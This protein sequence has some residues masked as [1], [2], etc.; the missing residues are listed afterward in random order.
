[1]PEN[2]LIYYWKQLQ[3]T[4]QKSSDKEHMKRGFTRIQWLAQQHVFNLNYWI[5]CHN[6]NK[7]TMHSQHF[8]ICIYHPLISDT[9]PFVNS[10]KSNKKFYS[11]D[12][13]GVTRFEEKQTSI[14]Y[15]CHMNQKI[16]SY[17]SNKFLDMIYHL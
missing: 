7:N 10:R 16:D 4:L 14:F 13:L 2:A 6:I 15:F 11:T 9:T 17:Q 5:L 8:C 1:M 3:K 12:F